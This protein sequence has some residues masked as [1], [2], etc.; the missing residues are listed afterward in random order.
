MTGDGVNDTPALKQAEV[1]IAMFN[2][3]DVAKSAASAVLLNQGLSAVPS[4]VIAGRLVHSRLFNWMTVRIAKT[5][6]ITGFTVILFVITG[7][8]VL[9]PLNLLELLILVDLVSLAM[10][11]DNVPISAIPNKWVVLHIATL[12][13]CIGILSLG[14]AIGLYYALL[15]SMGY[16][17][18]IVNTT[19]FQIVFWMGTANMYCLRVRGFFWE[20]MP[21]LSLTVTNLISIT[22]VM[23]TCSVGVD[24]LA[25]RAVPFWITASIIA[26]TIAF[27]LCMNN[28]VSYVLFRTLLP[29][30]ATI[31]RG[32]KKPRLSAT[33]GGQSEADLV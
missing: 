11:T 18:K 19:C 20:S 26:W 21:S 1:G 13:F 8:W 23:V 9:Q 31:L 7:T 29:H 17:S 28:V 24:V 25:L 5:I 32:S 27:Q 33:P 6:Q 12:S 3:T 30:E 22:F 2:A 4:M 10:S 14:Q 15:P 16:D